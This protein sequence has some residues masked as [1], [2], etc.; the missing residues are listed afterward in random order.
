METRW[1]GAAWMFLHPQRTHQCPAC[2]H[3]T[4]SSGRA[5]QTPP[6]EKTSLT[7]EEQV[8]RFFLLLLFFWSYCKSLLHIWWN[9]YCLHVLGSLPRCFI[10]YSLHYITILQPCPC[11]TSPVHQCHQHSVCRAAL[12]VQSSFRQKAS[13]DME[14]VP[15]SYQRDYMN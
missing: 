13:L 8:S 14:L 2:P 4:L 12:P 6:R 5:H 10:S 11:W 9:S 1:P 3:P 15:N 7:S